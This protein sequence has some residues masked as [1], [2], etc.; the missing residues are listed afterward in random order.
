MSKESMI[1]SG[2]GGEYKCEFNIVAVEL[3]HGVNLLVSVVTN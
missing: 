2:K 1:C 3:K